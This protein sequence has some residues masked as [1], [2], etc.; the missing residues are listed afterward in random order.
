MLTGLPENTRSDLGQGET[1][2]TECAKVVEVFRPMQNSHYLQYNRRRFQLCISQCICV[3]N[4]AISINQWIYGKWTKN[5]REP[6]F[7]HSFKTKQMNRNQY[8]GFDYMNYVLY[9]TI[10]TKGLTI[11]P[12]RFHETNDQRTYKSNHQCITNSIK[13]ISLQ[14]CKTKSY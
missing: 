6:Q 13:R 4:Y 12:M 8:Q 1:F 9:E 2:M 3:K 5:L 10:Y 14:S 11:T 7:Y